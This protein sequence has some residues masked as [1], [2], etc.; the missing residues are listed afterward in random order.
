MASGSG[1]QTPCNPPPPVVNTSKHMRSSTSAASCDGG[2]PLDYTQDLHLK[3]SKKIAQL[4]KVIYALNT[5]NDE[6]EEELESLKETHEDE[7]QHIVTET[8][9][10]I[11]QFKNKMA[12]EGDLR[13]R[14]ASL[15]DLEESVEMHEHMK[16][17]A[18][19]EFD[20][21]RQRTED[22]QLCTEAQHTQRVVSMSREVEEMRRDFEEKL[23]AFGQAQAQVECEKRRALDELRA[24]HR[25]EVEELLNAQHNQSTSCSEDQEKLA[26]L[27]RQEVESLMERVEELTKDKVHL[28]E[29]YEAKLAKAQDFYERELEAM[30]RTHQLTAENLLAWKRTEVELRKEFQAQ[31]V[32]LQRSLSTLRGEL[33]RAQEDA[34]ENR[35]KTNRL[36][37]SLTNAEG[38]IKNLHQQLGEALQDGEIWVMQLKDTEDELENSRDRIQQQASEILHKASQ[39]GSLQATQMSHE[40]TIRDLDQEQSRLKDKTSRLEGEREALLNHSQATDQQHRQQVLE[41][42]QSLREEHQG[43][44][45]ELCRLRAR[46]EAEALRFKEAQV[47]SLE[48]T[49]ERQRV[50]REEVRQEKEEEKELLMTKM[51]QEF[52]IKRLSLEEQRDRL[53]QQLDN[54]KEELSAKV[55]MADQEVSHLQEQV[56]EGEHKLS[57]AHSQISCLKD[58]Q[59]KLKVELDATRARVRETSNLLTDLQEEIESEKQQHEARLISIRTEEKQRMDKMA[60][61]LDQKWT[62]A[63]REELRLLKEELTEEY[64]AD[65]QAA[66]AQLSQQNDLE[67]MSARESWQRKVE[68]LLEQISL[69]KQSLELQLSQSQSALQQ[70]QSQFNQER[71][72]LSQQLKEL[73]REHQRREHR[74]Q[75]AHC[76]ALSTMEEERHHH[77]MALEERLKQEQR[78]EVQALKEAHRRTLEIL[79]QQSEQELQTLRYELEDEGKAMLASLRSELNHLHATAVEHLKQIH[80]KENSVANKELENALHHSHEQEQELLGRISDLQV[81]VCSRSNRITDLD[82]E[83]HSLNQTIDTLT[84]ELELKGKEVLRVRSETN[85]QIRAHEQELGKRHDRALGELSGAHHRETHVM[86][87]DFNKAQE[88]LKDKISALQILL[89]GTE[90][91]FRNRESRPEDLAAIAELRAMVTERET[92]VKKLVDDKKFYQLELV[93]RETGFSKVFNSSANVG[94]INPLVKVSLSVVSRCRGR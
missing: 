70:L 68:D 60:D 5:K 7:V 29:E 69:L 58:T 9:D 22:A 45:K 86:L 66:L 83:I 1:W 82:H 93:N 21:Y 47:R 72:L 59:E 40:T 85:H 23:R 11:M 84:R 71:E 57:S 94:V 30:R 48:E 50:L 46:Y 75:E 51:R 73:Q 31:E 3:M 17:Q 49:E 62:D 15:E 2:W 87:A 28:V 32:A 33:Q 44:E 12:D 78:E 42:E 38:T 91:K 4:T 18:L 24:G 20:M 61:D 64:E 39:I 34:R 35:D 37:T 55:N 25:Q 54:L 36:Q 41:L 16:R 77:I 89:E 74:L 88:V 80:L 43:Y 53:Q 52:E 8:R 90:E 13:R 81:D 65:K 19:A 56:R 79:R 63:L 10:K 6:H 14:L 26:D 92:L 67:V 27:H 76:C